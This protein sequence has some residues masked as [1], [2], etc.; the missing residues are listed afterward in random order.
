MRDCFSEAGIID[1]LLLRRS[2]LGRKSYSVVHPP[3]IDFLEE[4]DGQKDEA[5]VAKGVP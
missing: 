1:S 4:A 2:P 5:K 3:S